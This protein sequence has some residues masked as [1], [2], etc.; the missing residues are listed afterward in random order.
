MM[1]DKWSVTQG[2]EEVTTVGMRF[3]VMDKL[4]LEIRNGC[5]CIA[6][7]FHSNSYQWVEK[8]LQEISSMG[9]KGFTGDIVSPETSTS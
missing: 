5:S 6:N 4:R 1:E 9:R 7:T 2:W 3:S 8:V